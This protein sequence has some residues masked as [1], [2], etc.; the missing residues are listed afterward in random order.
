MIKLIKFVII[1]FLLTSS[2]KVYAGCTYSATAD[3]ENNTLVNKKEKYVCKEDKSF[4]YQFFTEDE[5]AKTATMTILFI[6][7]NI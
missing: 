4:L 2:A 6:M 7:E 5:W 1:I 3:V